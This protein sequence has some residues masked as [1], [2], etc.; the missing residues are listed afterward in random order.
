[1][2]PIILVDMG[3]VKIH[4][5]HYVRKI[6][7]MV[8][9]F[10]VTY[11]PGS[12]H[13]SSA[14]CLYMSFLFWLCREANTR[15][16]VVYANIISFLYRFSYISDVQS[17]LKYELNAAIDANNIENLVVILRDP[18]F[19]LGTVDNKIAREYM[20]YLKKFKTEHSGT[21]AGIQW[22]LLTQTLQGNIKKKQA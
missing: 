15:P 13:C 10:S 2:W 19:N 6:I 5:Q 8:L 3:I 21:S 9:E 12:V 4:I 1:M 7:P 20:A 17:Y 16:I 22:S 11:V 18:V 14:W